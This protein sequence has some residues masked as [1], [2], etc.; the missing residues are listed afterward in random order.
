MKNSLM[1]L[2][3]VLGATFYDDWYQGKLTASGV[4]FSQSAY[5]GASSRYAL[6][7][8]LKLTRGG[9]QVIVK[10]VD[11]CNCELDL[12]KIAFKKLGLLS[13]GRIKVQV[14]RIYN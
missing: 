14:Q 3:L 4:P 5:H 6:G 8:K 11:K 9:K 2:I 1:S 13:E 12:S 7:T 10:I